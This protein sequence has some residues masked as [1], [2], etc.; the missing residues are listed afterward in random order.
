MAYLEWDP[1]K[2]ISAVFLDALGKFWAL[3]YTCLGVAIGAPFLLTVSRCEMAYN[4]LVFHGFPLAKRAFVLGN[5]IIS[6]Y[7]DLNRAIMTY[8]CAA[9]AKHGLPLPQVRTVHLGRHEEAH[10][11]QY[12]VLGPLFLPVYLL[13]LL[14]PSP[15]PFERA[16]DRYAYSGEGWW[17]WRL[18]R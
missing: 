12:Q 1:T 18:I 13:T 5:V 6:P 15:T 14:L 4:A 7:T 8:E 17:P 3:P 9:R 16:A 2:A 10:T 11:R